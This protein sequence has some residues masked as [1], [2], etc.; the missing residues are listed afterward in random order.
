M[1][2][3]KTR[4]PIVNPK[5]KT[6]SVNPR[7]ATTHQ[8]KTNP[9]EQFA[10]L[11]Y[12]SEKASKIFDIVFG[13]P[14]AQALHVAHELTLF[15]IINQHQA[16]SLEEISTILK[17]QNR[18]AQALLSMCASLELVNL[19]K[20][21]KY[22]LT[23]MAKHFLLKESP[24]YVGGAL[25]ITLMNNEVYLF[26]SFK[27]ALFNNTSQ[28]YQGKEL[29]KTNEEQEELAKIFT[30]AMHGKSMAMANVWPKKLDLSNHKT[31]LDIGGGSAAHS[32]A[33]TLHW[34]HL[35]AIVYEQ[36]AVSKVAET[37]INHFGLSQRIETQVADMWTDPFPHADIHFYS[38]IFHDWS[39]EKCQFLIEKSYQALKSGGRILIH[40]MLFDQ[41]KSGPLSVSAYNIMMLL[42]TEGGQQF[43]NH[44]LS[45]ILLKAGFTDIQA[46]STGFGDWVLLSALKK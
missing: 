43:S 11:N 24:F 20:Q 28:I 14:A 2:I 17:I 5:E 18:P 13:M 32:I 23:D 12:S 34:D 19:N 46:V 8:A 35:N 29:F 33:A 44:E 26:K 25:D 41:N 7:N 16:L 9:Q 4:D 38:D 40:E 45:S 21:H 6:G 36:P 27:Q 15:E 31:F 30:H 37:Y 22:E 1:E 10:S 3:T 42:W 39:V